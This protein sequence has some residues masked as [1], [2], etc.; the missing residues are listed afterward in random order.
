[1][2]DAPGIDTG[3]KHLI[4]TTSDDMKVLDT[5]VL[6]EAVLQINSIQNMKRLYAMCMKEKASMRKLVHM[7][8]TGIGSM[9]SS[10]LTISALEADLSKIQELFA[11]RVTLKSMEL[12][13]ENREI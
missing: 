1:M 5:V 13:G 4:K 8:M 9:E 7:E 6:G 2:D 3:E 10:P 11:M 12:E